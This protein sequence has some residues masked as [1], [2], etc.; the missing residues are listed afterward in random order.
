MSQPR[1]IRNNN[2][3][4]LRYEQKWGWPGVVGVDANGFARF[5]KPEEGLAQFGRQLMRYEK[6]GLK[7][8]AQIVPVYAPKSDNNNVSAY[9]TAVCEDTG[10]GAH[11]PLMLTDRAEMI[12]LMRA[13]TAHENGP[14]PD[15]IDWYDDA[16][17]E[18]AADLLKPLSRSRT[19]VGSA[20]AAG[21]TAAQGLL[22]VAQESISQGSDAALMVGSVWPEIAR[23]VLIAVALAGIGYAMYAR[24]EARKEGIR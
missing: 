13:F 10:I 7:T 14:A 15:G 21:A 20:T 17:Y 12:G 16:V 18:R 22:D 5:S 6:R 23:W 11:E 1:G 2:P 4:N 19:I 3:G 9:L 24:W 8:L